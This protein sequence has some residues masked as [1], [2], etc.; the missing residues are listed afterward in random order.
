MVREGVGVD[1]VAELGREHAAENPVDT[2]LRDED[3]GG[4]PV[5]SVLGSFAVGD[6][7]AIRTHDESGAIE[8]DAD[9]LVT[10]LKDLSKGFAYSFFPTRRSSAYNFDCWAA[11]EW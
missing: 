5:A 3:I 1:V 6:S 9:V 11:F 7:L 4:V 8:R 2:G 10:A